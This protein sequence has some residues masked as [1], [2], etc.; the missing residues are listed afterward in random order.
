ML[1]VLLNAKKTISVWIY[2]LAQYDLA[3]ALIYAHKKGDI[4]VRVIADFASMNKPGSK[5]QTSS[6]QVSVF[7]HPKGKNFMNYL[8]YCVV[9]SHVLMTGPLNWSQR[10]L[11]NEEVI[12]I[13]RN[14][15]ACPSYVQSFESK[16][17]KYTKATIKNFNGPV[18]PA[19]PH[20]NHGGDA[21]EA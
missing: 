10:T 6:K 7:Y 15:A 4:N 14:N 20:C 2:Q 3:Q 19:C 5:I 8:K 11:T 16:C 18:V 13:W 21:E 17:V 9:D 1:M 12:E